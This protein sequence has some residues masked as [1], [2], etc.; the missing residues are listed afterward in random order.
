[1]SAVAAYLAERSQLAASGCI[2]WVGPRTRGGYG[3]AHFGGVK[4]TAHR[5]AYIAKH[6]SV[7]EGLEI[8]HLC[9]TPAC[10]NADH[11]EAVTHAE[12]V[13]RSAKAGA[14]HCINGHKFTEASTYVKANGTRSCRICNAERQRA[15]RAQ[16][17]ERYRSYDQKRRHT[18]EDL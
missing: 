13:R 14:T 6:G 3:S 15:L 18:H 8:D 9:R 1:M 12:N 10:I 7:P 2:V 5:L 4:T 17:P 11:L 16:N